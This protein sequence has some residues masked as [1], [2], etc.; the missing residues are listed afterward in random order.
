MLK[1]KKKTE[2]TEL[3]YGMSIRT[4]KLYSHILKAA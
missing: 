4:N 1:E 3:L 2:A